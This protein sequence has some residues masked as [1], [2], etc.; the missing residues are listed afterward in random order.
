MW[1]VTRGIN[2]Y[3]QQGEYFIVAFD[4]KPTLEELT[5]INGKELAE[6]LLSE[7]RGGRRG[8]EYEWYYLTELQNGELYTNYSN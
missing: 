3:D 6:H 7:S 4:H 5:V 1:I 2:E 8:V